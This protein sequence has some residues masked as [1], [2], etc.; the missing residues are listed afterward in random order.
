MSVQRCTRVSRGNLARLA[1]R[2]T[3][4]LWIAQACNRTLR[5]C[6]AEQL[7]AIGVK[8]WF[9]V[10]EAQPEYLS[11]YGTSGGGNP[12]GAGRLGKC[13]D[14]GVK[15]RSSLDLIG[16]PLVDR[17]GWHRTERQ[18]EGEIRQLGFDPFGDTTEANGE[19]S[20]W[21]QGWPPVPKAESVCESV[22]PYGGFDGLGSSLQCS[23]VTLAWQ[24]GTRRFRV[25]PGRAWQEMMGA[26]VAFGRCETGINLIQLGARTRAPSCHVLLLKQSQSSGL[27][28]RFALGKITFYL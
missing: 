9:V 10:D 18:R 4:G 7:E 25:V 11:R 14:S 2:E 8:P 1:P 28:N 13:G 15:L 23:A 27:A 3:G 12:R 26:R 24:P 6:V 16:E 22:C 17:F 5:G 19:P 20:N 21:W